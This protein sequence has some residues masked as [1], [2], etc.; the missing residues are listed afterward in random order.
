MLWAV[1]SPW[2]QG[3]VT[4]FSRGKLRSPF[5]KGAVTF[6]KDVLKTFFLLL[7]EGF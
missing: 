3:D 7:M 1:P 2:V 5:I 4:L 6:F